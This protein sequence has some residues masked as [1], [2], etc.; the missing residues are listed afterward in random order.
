MGAPSLRL[1]PARACRAGT[2]RASRLRETSGLAR[3]RTRP[4]P[5]GGSEDRS[6]D[7]CTSG[8][9]PHEDTRSRERLAQMPGGMFG[10]VHE[11]PQHG[12]RQ[13]G[14]PTRRSSRRRV[15]SV[16]RN[17]ASERSMVPLASATS[18]ARS[19]AGSPGVSSAA[20]KRAAGRSACH[21]GRR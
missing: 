4:Q 9:V 20:R 11:E 14:A 15:V 10:G 5:E 2:R 21:R 3:D 6:T 16:V 19:G 18:V 12:G 13:S 8:Y 17:W 7:V 1:T